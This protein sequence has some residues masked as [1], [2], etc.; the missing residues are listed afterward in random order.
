VNKEQSHNLLEVRDLKVYFP[1]MRGLLRKQIAEVKAVD[2][3]TFDVRKGEVLG[4]VGESGCG[5]TTVAE[6]SWDSTALPPE[7]SFLKVMILPNG[8]RKR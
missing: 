4:L 7:R 8:L 2:G 6:A 5:K 3:V 1:V